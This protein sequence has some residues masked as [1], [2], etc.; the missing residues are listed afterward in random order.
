MS[1][2]SSLM[3]LGFIYFEE[4]VLAGRA[5]RREA[6]RMINKLELHIYLTQAL[7]MNDWMQ[8]I[9]SMQV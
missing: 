4:S 9:H 3:T 8:I 6:T 2:E 5:G 7:T 1:E